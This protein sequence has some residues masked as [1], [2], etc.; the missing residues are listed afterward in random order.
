MNY[1]KLSTLAIAIL[2]VT[3]ACTKQ[4]PAETTETEVETTETV[5]AV[6]ETPVASTIETITW[7]GTKVV[8]ESHVGT[9]SVKE[10]NLTF[11]EGKLT[12]GSIV[13]DMTSINDT[14]LEGEWK[15]K[16]EGHLKSDDFFSTETYPTSTLAI[17][18]VEADT[19]GGYTVVADLTIKA[20]TLEETFAVS[21][22]AK[23]G[24]TAYTAALEIDRTK[25]DVKYNS[26][27]FFKDLGDKAI[28]DIIKLDVAI[29]VAN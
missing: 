13:V 12:G 27:N 6:E 26:T 22:E 10:N 25:Y 29:E 21:S 1:S 4:K 7:T 8:G 9:I 16:L 3:A 2:F 28:N 5:A 15:T 24:T 17:K 19:T 23:E 18:S 20:T 14:D 11:E